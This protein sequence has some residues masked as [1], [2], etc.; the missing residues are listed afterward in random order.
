MRGSGSLLLRPAL[1]PPPGGR[2]TF[3]PTVH[4]PPIEQPSPGRILSVE[5]VCSW[6][7]QPP[8]ICGRC[9]R[10]EEPAWLFLGHGLPPPA[11]PL[12]WAHVPAG[13]LAHACVWGNA[14]GE[15]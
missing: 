9:G 13:H 10:T 1:S 14:L 2:K 15:K 8:C 6:S 11:S 4:Q 7:T 12:V 3:D 5:R